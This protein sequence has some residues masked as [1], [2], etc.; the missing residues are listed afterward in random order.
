MN[1]G[2][3]GLGEV[4]TAIKQLVSA[5]H[6]VF[7]R[8]LDF[9]HIKNNHIDLLHVCI[10]YTSKFATSVF[11][12]ISE[13]SPKLVIINSTVKPGTTQDLFTKTKTNLV[14]APVMGIHPH[15]YQYFFKFTKPIGAVNQTSYRLAR[16]HFQALG[17]KTTR[18]NSPFE[19]ELAKV[20]ST[21]YYGWNILFEKWVHQLCQQHQSNF[22][23]VYT[24]FNQIYNQGYR[25]D[26]PHVT[27]PVL[28]HKPGPIGGHCVIP[29]AAIIDQWLDDDLIKFFIQQN[30]RLSKPS[31]G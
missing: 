9:D 29:N 13:K 19:T 6:Q 5:K 27:R 18:F 23:Q 14:H 24:R 22:N 4:G 8:D 25:Q 15:L 28:K 26:L 16:N 21:T 3:L 7:T 20:L 12:L 10:P 11:R 1:V 17:V 2:I 30:R 31:H